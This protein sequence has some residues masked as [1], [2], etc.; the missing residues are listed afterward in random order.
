[1]RRI[2]IRELPD[3]ADEEIRS[4]EAY[5]VERDGKVLGYLIPA[6]HVDPE[7]ARKS[8]ENLDR[9]IDKNLTYG[10]TRED[11]AEDMDLSRPFVPER[12]AEALN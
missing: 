8:F 7:E 2:D 11:L 4:G 5:A 1:M 6:R 10:Y 12:Q 9:V 3:Q